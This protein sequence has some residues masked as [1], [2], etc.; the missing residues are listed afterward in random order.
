MRVTSSR[1]IIAHELTKRLVQEECFRSPSLDLVKRQVIREHINDYYVDLCGHTLGELREVRLEIDILNEELDTLIMRRAPRL[2]ESLGPRHLLAEGKFLPKWVNML[3]PFVNM[4][5]DALTLGASTPVTA[6]LDVLNAIDMFLGAE[7]PMDY[8]FSALGILMALPALGDALGGGT[9]PL[10]ALAEKVRQARAGIGGYGSK[11]LTWIAESGPVQALGKKVMPILRP[12]LNH[13]KPGGKIFDFLAGLWNRAPDGMK[14]DLAAKTAEAGGS[15]TMLA[16]MA[17]A[18]KTGIA[19]IASMVGLGGAAS[20]SAD[21]DALSAEDV[22]MLGGVEAMD[23]VDSDAATAA[24][25]IYEPQGEVGTGTAAPVAP[26][27]GRLVLGDAPERDERATAAQLQA[28]DDKFP[29]S[30]SPSRNRLRESVTRHRMGVAE[31]YING[32][33]SL[34]KILS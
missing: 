20:S 34:S 29:S 23:K 11:A 13:F 1:G 17:E 5:V 14:K 18:L 32:D 6:T 9:G 27:I 15:T 24:L 28:L 2:A 12:V 26:A 21:G 4:S 22:D 10:F 33:M 30:N 3:L 8:L 31:A 25:D 7:G 19:S 16:K